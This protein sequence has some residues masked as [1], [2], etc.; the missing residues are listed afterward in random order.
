[1]G[2]FVEKKKIT[3]R[4]LKTILFIILVLSLGVYSGFRNSEDDIFTNLKL[5]EI[6]AEVQVYRDQKGIPTIIAQDLNDLIFVQGYEFARD[7]S[8]QL[9]IFHA[10]V[11]GELSEIF[12][13]DL[14]EAD[15]LL[16]A[17]NFKLIGI[18]AEARL[19][20]FYFGLIQSYVNGINL[21]FERHEFN[22]PWEFQVLGLDSNLWEV[23]DSLAVQALLSYN[24][25]F[26]NFKQELVRLQVMQQV[27][28][29]RSLEIL[30]INDIMVKQ[31]LQNDSS[32][33]TDLKTTFFDPLANLF[34]RSDFQGF[35]ANSWVL[36]GSQ[37]ETGNA[38][39]ANDPHLGFEIPSFWYQINL[40]LSDN[41]FNVQGF[42]IPGF[43]FVIVGHN[44]DVA[45]GIS[46][47]N[48]DTIDL[49]YIKNNKTHYFYD[50]T[51]RKFEVEEVDI[52]IAGL[53]TSKR[54]I[55][56]TE[57]GSVLN[58]TDD[59]YV[60]KW[61][62]LENV[63]RD[64]MTRAFYQV[65]IAKNI[66]NV[67][68]ALRYLTAPN[69]N[70]VFADNSNNIGAQNT[71]L[72]PVRKIGYGFIP[73]NG[74]SI[75]E[76]WLGFIDYDNMSYLENPNNG[77]I[78]STGTK[79][80]EKNSKSISSD[81]LSNYRNERI[82]NLL[83]DTTELKGESNVK[84]GIADMEKIQGDI[85]NLAAAE[86]LPLLISDIQEEIDF[87]S[88]QHLQPILDELDSW[89]YKMEKTSVAATIFAT[90]RILFV[91]AI[92]SD[93]LEAHTIR[94]VINDV[95]EPVSGMLITNKTDPWFDDIN[96]LNRTEDA[97][98]IAYN[99]LKLTNE[100]LEAK[101][102]DN[103]EN[104]KWEKIHLIS[105]NHV[106]GDSAPFLGGLNLGPTGVNGSTF[107][108]NSF[109]ETPKLV[110]NE[111]IY[112]STFGPSF[113]L[114]MEVNTIWNNVIG[115]HAPG[116]SGHLTSEHYDDGYGEWLTFT[117][118]IWLFNPIDVVLIQELTITYSHGE[119]N[120]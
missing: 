27:G 10:I 18:K 71:G 115:M 58:I 66:N 114:I 74:S 16:K 112:E 14:I 81:L 34:R 75:T 21:Y 91:E 89:D 87:T 26:A 6:N 62:M 73:K 97:S 76:A 56:K 92:F 36:A 60:I 63:E 108:I 68:E 17:L 7:R 48:I 59:W 47:S 54:V 44:M 116:M 94:L 82:S 111:I 102:G 39:I 43:P 50:E 84:L 113:R 19:D 38:I 96:T 8:F 93:E 69:L 45:W 85:K 4:I 57:I 41:T 104:W 106:M 98:E 23:S 67:H 103:I 72:I 25:D 22:L 64:Q 65:N 107:T 33:Y 55:Y 30:P 3:P 90:F 120:E 105:Y 40:Q 109:Q 28:V 117:Y 95:L 31:Y 52:H 15:V 86:I 9:Q 32:S 35:S 100:N 5:S 49:L 101:L 61:T 12:G 2:W 119:D 20:D 13:S 29:N 88:D 11:N 51:W 53:P 79:L 118:T 70:F 37:T 77:F 83:A 24:F 1:M 80:D 110:N 99:A 46:P 42:A 78:V